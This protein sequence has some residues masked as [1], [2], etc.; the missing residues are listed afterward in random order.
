[1]GENRKF[2]ARHKPSD[3]VFSELLDAFVVK[4]RVLIPKIQEVAVH[5]FSNCQ[6]DERKQSEP[7]MP[8]VR[9][10]VREQEPLTRPKDF[11]NLHRH[12]LRDEVPCQCYLGKEY[13][14]KDWSVPV[15]QE[16]ELKKC[17]GTGWVDYWRQP[18]V[19]TPEQE[20]GCLDIEGCTKIETTEVIKGFFGSETTKVHV[21]WKPMLYV[22]NPFVK[23]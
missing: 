5:G 19:F 20:E 13:T 18:G 12:V 21:A 15:G 16:C 14:A 8:P 11:L 3:D 4:Q 1:M 7:V 17:G 9:P 6:E 22:S 23:G 10:V 2:Q